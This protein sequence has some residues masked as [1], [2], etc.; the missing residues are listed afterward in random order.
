MKELNSKNDCPLV[1]IITI[2][3]NGEKSI[4]RTIK[5]VLNQN[6]SNI[7]YLIVDGGSSDGTINIIRKYEDKIKRWISEPDKGISDAFNKGIGMA[8]GDIVGFVNADDWYNENTV[9]KVV[10]FF[11]KF[12]AVYGD[13]QFWEGETVKHRTY[14][15]HGKLEQGMTLAHPAV[16][17]KRHMF[18]KYG[19]FDLNF[20]IAMD[21]EF[22]IK[23]YVGKEPFYNI[24]EVIMN[25]SLGGISDRNWLKAFAEERSLKTKYFGS[26]RS[27]YYFQKQIILFLLQ[28]LRFW[29]FSRNT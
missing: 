4:E 22:L 26:L 6:Y 20:K 15:D 14:A 5:S 12:S 23:L 28:R 29:L 8:T 27:T 18:Q 16:F 1:S 11:A 9:S 3:F 7:E 24:R 21:Y 17:V 13:V 19:M 10:P 2:V 25:M